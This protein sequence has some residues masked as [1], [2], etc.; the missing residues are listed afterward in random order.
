MKCGDGLYVLPQPLH[1]YRK[2]GIAVCG[3][4]AWMCCL[5]HSTCTRVCVCVGG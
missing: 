4:M 5:S 3:G 1:L 2:G